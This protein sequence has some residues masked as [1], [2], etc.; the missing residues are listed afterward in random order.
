LSNEK[1][2]SAQQKTPQDS[3]WIQRAH[4][5][6]QRAQGSQPSPQTGPQATD[7][8]VTAV[9]PKSLRLRSQHQFRNATRRGKRLVGSW[10]IIDCCYSNSTRLGVTVSKKYGKAH[11]RN[12]FKRLVREG[13]RLSREELPQGR[14]LNVR[15]RSAAKNATSKDIQK[16][17]IGLL[18]S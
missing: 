2:I 15:P 4:E 7:Q 11:E 6:C 10:I 1:N 13:F 14:D 8:S 12:R 9:F 18:S 17:L 16:E 3:S 5:N